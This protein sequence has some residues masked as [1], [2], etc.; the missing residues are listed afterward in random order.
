M[1]LWLRPRMWGLHAVAVIVAVF[2]LVGGSWQLGVYDQRQEH[3]RA[4]R[5]EVPTVPLAEVWSAG[6]PF[7]ETMNHRPVTVTGTFG[8]ADEQRWVS[9]REQDGRDGYWL[10]TPLVVSPGRAV[11]VVRGFAEDNGAL[12][13]PPTGEHTLR[14]VLEPGEPVAAETPAD[15]RVVAS[16]RVPALVNELPYALFPGFGISTTPEVAGGLTLVDVPAPEVSWTVGLRNLA[17][18]AQW[19]AFAAFAVFMWWRMGRDLVAAERARREQAAGT[20]AAGRPSRLASS[21]LRDR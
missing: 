3:E 20:S 16:V 17:Y 14:V 21:H 1:R 11:L 7:L 5:R 13:E 18:A 8:T 10:L 15:P 2:C 6:E 4:D 19:W 9:G 12:P